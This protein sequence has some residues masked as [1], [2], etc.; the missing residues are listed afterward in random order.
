MKKETKTN[1]KNKK[2][3]E[4]KEKQ[5]GKNPHKTPPKNRPKTAKKEVKKLSSMQEETKKAEEK[6]ITLNDLKKIK[7]ISGMKISVE[8]EKVKII[9][10]EKEKVKNQEEEIKLPDN[11]LEEIEE[12]FYI[13]KKK[14]DEI[15]RKLKERGFLSE[16]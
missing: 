11:Y 1:I 13:A 2:T 12:T 16:D 10:K 15:K 14:Y 4:T 7:S 3:A 8:K 9:K 5:K 6:K